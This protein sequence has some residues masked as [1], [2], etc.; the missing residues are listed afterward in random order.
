MAD[1]R[2]EVMH[3]AEDPNDQPQIPRPLREPARR[4]SAP[5]VA[6]VVIAALVV[7]A[8]VLL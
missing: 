4:V 7:L 1:P 8:I 2:H 3:P 5:A 6:T